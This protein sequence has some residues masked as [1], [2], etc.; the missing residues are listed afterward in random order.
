MGQDGASSTLPLESIDQ[1]AE[2]H[3]GQSGAV[4]LSGFRRKSAPAP[5]SKAAQASAAREIA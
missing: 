5:A 2:L 3:L 4:T 1:Q